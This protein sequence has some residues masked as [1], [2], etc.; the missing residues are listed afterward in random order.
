M[1][2]EERSLRVLAVRLQ[3]VGINITCQ[4]RCNVCTNEL[5]TNDTKPHVY[6]KEMLVIALDTSMWIITIPQIGVSGS[7]DSIAE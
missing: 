5:V 7:V 1:F 2:V 3:K 4:T 6:S